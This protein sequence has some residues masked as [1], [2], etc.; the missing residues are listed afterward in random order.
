MHIPTSILRYTLIVLVV[1]LLGIL[2]WW[3]FF[4]GVKQDTL[5]TTD[6]A[7]GAG[8]AAPS[9]GGPAGST[10]GNIV[11]SVESSAQE[12]AVAS[13][14]EAVPNLWQITKA[15][16]AGANFIQYGTT[17]TAVRFVERG[18]GYVLEANPETGVLTRITNTL[19]PRVYQTLL[20][21][22]GSIIL[23]SLDETGA[24]RTPIEL[25]RARAP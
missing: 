17:S 22:N 8:V 5:E 1:V 13:T 19:I 24:R 6:A 11:S 21:A 14:T 25:A 20:G 15:P 3:Y 7:R 12:N 23:R 16:V 18:T 9:F 2:L 4:L 10:Y